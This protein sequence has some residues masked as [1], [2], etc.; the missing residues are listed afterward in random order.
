MYDEDGNRRFS[1]LR[2]IFIC[3]IIAF[4]VFLVMWAIARSKQNNSSDCINNNNNNSSNAVFNSNI[5]YLQQVGTDYFTNDKLPTEVGQTTKIL[6]EDLVEGHYILQV[7]DNN[8]K[9]CDMTRSY[10]S[11]TKTETGYEMKTY[12][13]CGDKEDYIIKVL[14]CHDLC[15]NNCNMCSATLTEYQFKK[16]VTNTKTIYS[17]TKGTLNGKMCNVTTIV[18]TKKP[19][20]NTSSTVDIK[21]AVQ[22]VISGTKTKVDTVVKKEPLKV[23]T[24]TIINKEPLKVKET[25]IPGKTEKKCSTTYQKRDCN[26]T[27]YMNS[28]GS[29]VTTCSTCNIPVETC[30]NVTTPS[31]TTRSCPSGT[32]EQ[33]GSG[34]NL[35]CYKYNYTYTYSCPSGTDEQTGSGTNLKCYKYSYSCP[36]N[37]NYHEGSGANLSCYVVTTARFDLTCDVYPG[38][39]LD[40][41]NCVKTNTT[42]NKTCQSGYKLE[43]DVCNKYSTTTIPA[44]A[45]TSD[46][47]ETKYQWSTKTSI[48]GWTKTGK[49][50]TVENKACKK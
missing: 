33:T 30:Q 40:G 6:L 7:N 13:V 29:I 23:E 36:S 42:S 22:V 38:Y 12:L 43:K 46:K 50:R 2:M 25:V 48:E 35:K 24:T 10:V 9:A 15:N 41:S 27:A 1:L 26:C 20:V 4:F 28:D 44:T 11:V 47:T 31:T 19:T 16:T 17:C 21:K 45:K 34:T 8:G 32:D 14:G 18:D 37:S 3:L 49:T 5:N 39:K